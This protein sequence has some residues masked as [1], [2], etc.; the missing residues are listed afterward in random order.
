VVGYYALTTGGVQQSDAPARVAH[1]MREPIPKLLL[2]RRRRP[3]EPPKAQQQEVGV[4]DKVC[5]QLAA[6]D[7]NV[8]IGLAAGQLPL[9]VK[10]AVSALIAAATEEQQGYEGCATAQT[11]SEAQAGFNGIHGAKS[12]ANAVR[13]LLGL[14]ATP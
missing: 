2:G 10:D 9:D 8:A 7:H 13:V 6:D 12:Q 4:L 14:P 1:E 5:G 3:Q 11:A